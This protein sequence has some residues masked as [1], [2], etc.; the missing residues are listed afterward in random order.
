M[1]VTRF[2]FPGAL[3]AILGC[4]SPVPAGTLVN[5]YDNQ[6]SGAVTK[7]PVG[8]RVTFLNQGRSVHNA[9]AADGRWT[10]GD[11]PGRTGGEG[12]GPGIVF[13]SPGVHRYYC[14]YHGTKDGRGMAGVVVVGEVDYSPSPKGA[15]AAVDQPTGATRR[16]P[17]D[18]P[19]IQAAVDAAAPGDL[20]LI[21]RGVYREEVTV[22]T[23]SLVLR[24]VD[25]NEV[26]IDGEFVRGNGVV[27]LADAIAVENMT[28]RNALLNGFFWTGVRGFRGSYLTAYNNGDYGLYAFGSRD[29]VFEDSYASGSPDSGFYIGQCYP[30]ETVI[31]RVT[32]EHNGLGYSGT[33]AGGRLY[34]VSSTWRFNRAG[35]VPSSLDIELEPPQREAVYA[36]NLVYSN[37]NR[38]A[39]A[40]PL[41]LLA[42]GNGILLAGSLR[43]TVTGNVVVDHEAHGI[44]AAPLQDKN[45][46]P[47]AGN[48]IRDNIV[49]VSGR[50]DLANGGPGARGNCFSGN[51]F[52]SSAPAALETFQGCDR[53]RLPWWSDFVA[54]GTLFAR[55]MKATSVVIPDWRAQ[56][57]PPPQPS[58]PE[59][60]TA[61][62]RLARNVFASL[63]F[64]LGAARLPAGADSVIAAAR[65]P[66]PT[67]APAGVSF[68]RAGPLGRLGA[69]ATLLVIPVVLAWTAIRRPRRPGVSGWWRRI[70]PLMATAMAYLVVLAVSALYYGRL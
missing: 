2:C 66:R 34:L 7:I 37:N 23:P 69:N 5:M 57:V 16:V 27:A 43:D 26:I 17:N 25:R 62:V 24:G 1:R 50:A 68:R 28:A 53:L 52:E 61:P 3:A 13:D 30:C 38:L 67:G 70:R 18:Y 60:L 42:F 32:A 31:Q 14:T 21:D 39:P 40:I 8:T 65:L 35:I 51:R 9:V 33:N 59:A 45:Y 10:T 46:Y 47:A 49:L 19:T 36:A 4:G 15:I 56:P 44:L 41:N 11:V 20:V 48:V 29:G 63:G 22:T 64:D 6:Y 12:K 58:M 55:A 54:L